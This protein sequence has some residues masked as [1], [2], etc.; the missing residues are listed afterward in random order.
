[1]Q[2]WE[3][4][5]EMAPTMRDNEPIRT[6]LERIK[7]CSSIEEHFGVPR[8]CHQSLGRLGKDV[9]GRSKP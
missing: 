4:V 8:D 7:V 6:N 3:I 9:A 1:M 5:E 2:Q